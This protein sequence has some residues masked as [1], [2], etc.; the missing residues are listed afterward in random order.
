MEIQKMPRPSKFDKNEAVETVMQEIWS[1]GYSA[2]T[3]KSLSEKLGI[4][5]SSFYNA[6]DTREALFA[7]VMEVYAAR[8]PDAV[9]SDITPGEK[10]VPKIVEVFRAV[11]KQRAEDPEHR[12]CMIINTLNEVHGRDQEVLDMTAAAVNASTERFR[13]LL[14]IARAQGEIADDADIAKIAPALQNLLA[15]LNTM[16]RAVHDEDALWTPVHT[17]LQA[18]GLSCACLD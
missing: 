7:K 17:T 5:R 13:Q 18:L 12:G 8:S 2:A 15:G 16:A 10:V 14:A 1:H 9:L 4:T 3:V 6:F 11:A